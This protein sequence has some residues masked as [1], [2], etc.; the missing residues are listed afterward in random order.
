MLFCFQASF[1]TD[2]Y[3][4]VR[5]GISDTNFKN[6]LFAQS[7]FNNANDLVIMDSA[8]GYVIPVKEN[9]SIA[10]I[11]SENNL[12][13]I[14]IDNELYA[15]N[16]TG[17]ILISSKNNDLI[18]ITGLKRKGKQA[19]YRGYIEIVR[20]TKEPN[21][22][23]VVNVLSLKNYLKG[24]V[25]NEMPVSFGLE[26]LKAQTVAARNYAVTP[27]VKA[28]KEFDLCDSVAC[29]V[30]FGANTEE[31]L[32]N[33]AIEQ[34]NGVIALDRENNPILALYSSTAGGYTES[35]EFAFSDPITKAFPSKNIHYLT[36]V[37]DHRHFGNLDTDV[38]AEE[39]YTS[40]PESFDDGSPY[41]R[42][43]KVWTVKE[44]EDVLRKT[45][46]SQS[47]TGFVTPK[48]I[49]A[50]DIGNLISI[51]SILRGK[52]GKII[53]LEIQTTKQ[54]FTVE[55]ELVI[56]RCFQKNNISIPSANFVITYID[57]ETPTY[58]F[59]GG[60]FGHGVGLSQWGAGKMCKLGFTFD[61]I[62][63]HYYTGIKLATIPIDVLNNGKIVERRFYTDNDKAKVFVKNHNN[64]NK[65]KISINNRDIDVKLKEDITEVNISRYLQKGE[66]KISYLLLDNNAQYS[67]KVTVFTEV[68]GAINE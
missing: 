13:R 6:Y 51:K 44:L 1:A 25:P 43:S 33:K 14:Y 4:P 23:A 48:V 67:N 40:K 39:F 36:A 34:T 56:R 7:E 63:Q 10:K 37:P 19:S 12:F 65:M 21:K 54:I 28:Y 53:K 47:K 58:K 38:K 16:L 57:S 60:G 30:Y 20:D 64:L 45:L 11:T 42:W 22:F 68:K 35:Y 26:A 50:E 3:I 18:S 61:E 15:R 8:T 46:P 59:S 62:L 17:P 41:Y 24:V 2:N 31:A 55:K 5:V 32:S 29:Q 52:S 27:R 66:N 9:S 49:S